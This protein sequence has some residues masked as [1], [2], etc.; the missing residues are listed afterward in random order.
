MLRRC[1]ND[2][3]HT[4]VGGVGGQLWR[5]DVESARTEP[6]L[7]DYLVNQYAVMSNDREVAFTTGDS[8]N[9]LW[10]ASTL[11]RFAPRKVGEHVR[12]IRPGPNGVWYSGLQD[13]KTVVYRTTADGTPPQKVIDGVYLEA[14]SPDGK[15][16]MVGRDISDEDEKESQL[17]AVN[18]ADPGNSVPIC[19][20]CWA[21][22]SGDGRWVYISIGQ[23]VTGYAKREHG[24]MVA[25]PVDP[26]T[27]LPRIIQVIRDQSELLKLPGAKAVAPV[28]AGISPDGSVIAFIRSTANRNLFRVPL[29]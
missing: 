23:Q 28:G 12:R 18:V 25:V 14:V 2:R 26:Q 6:V 10:I 17:E 20:N 1:V 24:V 4:N 19:R 29:Q 9:E 15:R 13:G 3:T 11:A 5:A 8:L 16:L 22:W 7:T 27:G 21:E